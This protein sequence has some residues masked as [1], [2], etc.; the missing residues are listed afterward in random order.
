MYSLWS[1][2]M[3]AND[4]GN[5]RYTGM[6]LENGRVSIFHHSKLSTQM[7]VVVL[8]PQCD[9]LGICIQS[10]TKPMDIDFDVVW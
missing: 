6:T 5:Q 10:L 8:Q 9:S 2:H 7:R 4:E 3:I 1:V